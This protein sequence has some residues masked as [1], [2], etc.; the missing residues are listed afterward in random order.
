MVQGQVEADGLIDTFVTNNIASW[1]TSLMSVGA[2][3]GS[4]LAA[5]FWMRCKISVAV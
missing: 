1:T 4:C 5:M 2:L 3:T